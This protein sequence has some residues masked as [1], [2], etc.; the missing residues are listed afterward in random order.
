MPL[1]QLR[2]SLKSKAENVNL[3]IEE[4]R[5][6]MNKT[7]F[8][9]EAPPILH[10]GSRKYKNANTGLPGVNS[11]SYLMSHTSSYTDL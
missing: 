10:S 8:K 11:T 6:K 3:M 5:K 7:V 9:I 4:E 1:L 2:L